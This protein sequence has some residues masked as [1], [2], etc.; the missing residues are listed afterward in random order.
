MSA[1]TSKHL[2]LR[3]GPAQVLAA[4]EDPR[5]H[6]DAVHGRLIFSDVPKVRSH[7]LVGVLPIGASG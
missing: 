6:R 7:G 4:R 2:A 3:L 5:L 1:L